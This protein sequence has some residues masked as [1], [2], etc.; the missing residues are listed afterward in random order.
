MVEERTARQKHLSYEAAIRQ[1]QID[2]KA[3]T[4]R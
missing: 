1:N 2:N 4:R 3:H